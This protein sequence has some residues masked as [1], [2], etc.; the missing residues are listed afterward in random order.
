[1]PKIER[2]FTLEVKP[3]QYLN[4][5]SPTELQE[6]ALLISSP[7]YQH[8]MQGKPEPAEKLKNFYLSNNSHE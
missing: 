6:L 3:E 7:R 5:C 8:K 2:F 1:M 4:A